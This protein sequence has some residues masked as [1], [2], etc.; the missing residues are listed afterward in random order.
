MSPHNDGPRQR[1]TTVGPVQLVLLPEPRLIGQIIGGAPVRRPRDV[2]ELR[3]ANE[4]DGYAECELYD[5]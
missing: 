2:R 5:I 3:I 1:T 4:S